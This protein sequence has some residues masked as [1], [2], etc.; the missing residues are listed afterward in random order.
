[1]GPAQHSREKAS[2]SATEPLPEQLNTPHLRSPPPP[3]PSHAELLREA[4]PSQQP[5]LSGSGPGARPAVSAPRRTPAPPLLT[6]IAP[7]NED[8]SVLCPC[9]ISPCV[10]ARAWDKNFPSPQNPVWSSWRTFWN[11]TRSCGRPDRCLMVTRRLT[12]SS[13]ASPGAPHSSC[14]ALSPPPG[15][16]HHTPKP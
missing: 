9:Y 6:L 13:W 12:G 5:L 8:P 15:S 16:D 7:R 1:M 14:T 11:L 10:T 3:P 4:G 2:G